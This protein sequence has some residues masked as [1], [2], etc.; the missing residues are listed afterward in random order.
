MYFKGSP[1][2]FKNFFCNQQE[3]DSFKTTKPAQTE[4]LNLFQKKPKEENL[5]NFGLHK[6]KERSPLKENIF[7]NKPQQP[8]LNQAIF[9]KN[10]FFEEKPMKNVEM[11]KTPAPMFKLCDWS[12]ENFEIG[13]PLGR[14]KFGHVYLARFNYFT[15]IWL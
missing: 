3:N 6:N 12:L 1:L 8:A 2:N 15:N 5:H 4:P 7:K 10:A 9:K 14:G 13:R 11:L